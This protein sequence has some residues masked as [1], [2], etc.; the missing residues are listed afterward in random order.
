MA[1]TLARLLHYLRRQ[2]APPCADADAALL[3]RFERLRDEHAFA[4]LVARHGPMVL[5]VCRR[6][7]GDAHDAEDAFQATFLVLARK[8]GSLGRPGALAGWLYGVASRVALKAR[9]AR[10]RRRDGTGLEGA[11]EPP[12]PRPDPL[13]ELTARDLLHIL[14][15]E[16]QR[17]PGA[18]RLPIIL[19]CLEGLSQEDAA[20]QLGW[21]AGAVKGRLERGRKRLHERLARRGLA[22][23]AALTVVEVSRG[24]AM[25]GRWLSL[26]QETVKAA[27]LLGA[28]QPAPG[29]SRAAAALAE[30]VLRAMLLTKAKV[31]AAVLVALCVVACGAVLASAGGE[32]APRQTGQEGTPPPGEAPKAEA[33]PKAAAPAPA[34][35]RDPAEA[36]EMPA[37][38]VR[39]EVKGKLIRK[40]GRH[41][42]QAKDAIFPGTEVLVALQRGEDKNRAL[43]EHLK[44]LED[45]LVV[46]TGFLDCRRLGDAKGELTLYLHAEDQV[47][48]AGKK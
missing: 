48:A 26:L 9:S 14:E 15:E 27:T 23:P 43:D 8:A 12:D 35:E 16:V 47:R 30:E 24:T 39:V 1:P 28:G 17:L 41:Y 11:P 3:G 19:C 32:K 5:N 4:D 18:Y 38:Y 20:R 21:T 44:A 33:P 29:G 37:S 25:A 2:A 6:V 22:L 42:V 40:A 45:Q 36:K 31:G 7:L 46:A 34:R 10:T 13:A